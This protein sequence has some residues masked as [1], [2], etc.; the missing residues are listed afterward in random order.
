[1]KKSFLVIGCIATL[2]LVFAVYGKP[3]GQQSPVAGQQAPGADAV[4]TQK[5]LVTQY[6]MTCH[7]DK[8]KAAKMDSENKIDFDTLD[9]AHVAKDAERWEL[10]VRKLRAGM[11]PP[12]N[13]RRPDPATYKGLI[14]WL[15]NELDKNAVAYTPPPGLHR[16][17]RT[18]YANVVKDLLD[19]DIDPAKYLPSDDS[20]HGFDNIA[21][22]LGV[23]STLVE[24]YVSAAQKVSRLAIGE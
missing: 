14:T 2:S 21:G 12:E 1:M 23:S 24:A 22:A 20:T 9:I 13:M 19:L 15:E 5:A 6:C 3:A 7:S 18:E 16:L 4:A 8:A 17:N 11:M 10:I